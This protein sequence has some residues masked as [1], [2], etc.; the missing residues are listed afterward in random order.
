MAALAGAASVGASPAAAGIKA[1]TGFSGSHFINR[2]GKASVASSEHDDRRSADFIVSFGS[3]VE[4]ITDDDD[5]E[6][7]DAES[8]ESG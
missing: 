2:G 3:S 5:D 1:I 6:K 7:S 4:K 8:E